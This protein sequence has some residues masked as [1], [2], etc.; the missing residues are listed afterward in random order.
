MQTASLE[1]AYINASWE[2]VC[3]TTLGEYSFPVVSFIFGLFYISV[4][5]RYTYV[6]ICVCVY[7]YIFLSYVSSLM[8]LTDE[9]FL[10]TPGLPLPVPQTQEPRCCWV[11]LGDRGKYQTLVWSTDRSPWKIFWTAVTAKGQG[12]KV[13][14]RHFLER[15]GM[16]G[17]LA[18][19]PIKVFSGLA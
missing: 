2:I 6:C 4:S 15:G 5:I 16:N 1:T 14:R 12:K 11:H 13:R 10:V 7:I 18:D 9:L 17:T 19:A 3:Q 8:S